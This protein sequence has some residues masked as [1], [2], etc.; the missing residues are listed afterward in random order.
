MY[1]TDPIA[2]FLT[3]IRNGQ[4]ANHAEVVIPANKLKFEIAKILSRT[5][6]VGEVEMIDA[7]PQ[8]RIRV[9]LKYDQQNKPIIRQIKRI[10]KPS[11]RVYVSVDEI[12][13]I[14]NGLGISI[15]STS[16]GVL[17]GNEARTQNVG[18]EL[19]CSVY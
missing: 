10:S 7:Q 6:Y 11:R 16:R 12:P 19:L 18:G 15:V 17:T 1:T 9:A 4:M 14:L 5:G 3:R 8:K 2:D 13:S